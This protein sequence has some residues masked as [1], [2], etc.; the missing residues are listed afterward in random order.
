LFNPSLPN[1]QQAVE[2]A[3]KAMGLAAGVPRKKIRM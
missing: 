2:K 3:R 1:A